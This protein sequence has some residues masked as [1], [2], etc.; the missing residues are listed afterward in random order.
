ML[1]RHSEI[2]TSRPHAQCTVSL[3]NDMVNEHAQISAGNGQHTLLEASVKK[4]K[5]HGWALLVCHQLEAQTDAMATKERKDAWCQHV[6][7]SVEFVAPL[8]IA[9]LV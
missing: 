7:L 3:T 5:G 2:V 1:R 6:M 9:A 4:I 8:F